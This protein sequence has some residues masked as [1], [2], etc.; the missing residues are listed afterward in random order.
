[1]RSNVF[2]FP[3]LGFAFCFSPVPGSAFRAVPGSALPAIPAR[4]DYWL[5]RRAGTTGYWLRR[6]KPPYRMK[7]SSDSESSF[8]ALASV[9]S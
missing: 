2:R 6:G 8:A 7:S 5:S 9:I 1:M 3:V 4:R